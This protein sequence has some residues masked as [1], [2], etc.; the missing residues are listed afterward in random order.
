MLTGFHMGNESQSHC[1]F[2][3][4]IK[5]DTLIPQFTHHPKKK[6]A[7]KKPLFPD[8]TVS[9]NRKRS[10][11]SEQKTIF[12]F[13]FHLWNEIPFHSLWH[14]TLP[15]GRNG[16]ETGIKVPVLLSADSWT[17][18]NSAHYQVENSAQHTCR[19]GWCFVTWT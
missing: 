14:L 1:E 6:K 13:F 5:K 10:I 3:G 9:F 15:L 2:L 17:Q 11:K 16:R 19:V 7:T 18:L 12:I 8:F 4:L